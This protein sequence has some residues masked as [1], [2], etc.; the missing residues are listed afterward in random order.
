[1]AESLH[2]DAK[3]EFQMWAQAKYNITPHY[4]VVGSS[5]PD[6]AKLFIV[7]VLLNADVWGEGSGHSKQ[8]AAQAA[9]KVAMA[10]VETETL[11]E[12]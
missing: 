7:Q 4:Q 12:L 8:T 5:G 2:K 1:M 6:H 3:S 10:K 11:Q 9:A